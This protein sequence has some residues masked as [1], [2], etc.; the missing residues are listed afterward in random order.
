MVTA[1]DLD[2]KQMSGNMSKTN[3]NQNQLSPGDTG[4]TSQPP[5][6]TTNLGANIHTM[7]SWAADMCNTLQSIQGQLK[8]QLQIQNPGWQQ[9]ENQMTNQNTRMT[10][11]ESEIAQMSELQRK[12]NDTNKTIETINSEVDKLKN[13]KVEI[14]N[15]LQYDSENLDDLIRKN[16]DNDSKMETL[17][18][19]IE[20]LEIQQQRADD[21][22]IDV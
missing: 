3:D 16:T 10:R 20:Q 19:K 14:D 2:Q 7:Q 17:A 9:I 21:K 22:I 6:S 18:Q 1:S 4:I 8:D 11:I 12:L 15:S 13:H 5:L